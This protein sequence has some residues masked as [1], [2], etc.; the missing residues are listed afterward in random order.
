MGIIKEVSPQDDKS[1]ETDELGV[2]EFQNK[3]FD[4]P[5][6]QD[7]TKA[8]YNALGRRKLTSYFSWNPFSWYSFIRTTSRRTTDVGI[9]GNM[10][11]EGII[12]GG[13]LV[14]SKEK[15]VVFQYEEETGD[16]VPVEEIVE[17]I[18]ANSN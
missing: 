15:G 7:E 4:Y 1:I 8:F 2:I 16:P 13:V 12:L 6:Y 11:G 17:A 5:V 14:I 10:K 3:Y 9:T 18:L